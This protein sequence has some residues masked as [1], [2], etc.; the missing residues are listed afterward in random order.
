MER[1]EFK[2]R[3]KQYKKA[4]EENPGLKYWEWKDIPRYDV[5]TNS[6]DNGSNTSGIKT[7]FT[8][9]GVNWRKRPTQEQLDAFY[10]GD[11]Q[12]QIA[13]AQKAGQQITYS[14]PSY[15]LDEVVVTANRPKQNQYSE[16]DFAKDVAGFVP[17]LGDAIDIYDASKSLYDGNYSQ[18]ALL[19]AGLLL[20]NWLEKGGKYLYKGIRNNWRKFNR[21]LNIGINQNSSYFLGEHIS[22]VSDR[23]VEKNLRKL[24]IERYKQV[25]AFDENALNIVSQQYKN[26]QQRNAQSTKDAIESVQLHNIGK[27]TPTQ[28]R[29]IN[30]IFKED[31][32]YADFILAHPELNPLDVETV[33]RFVTKQNSFIRGVYSDQDNDGLIKS[34]MTENISDTSKK[35]G[36]D[37]LGTNSTGIYVSNSGEIA[38]KFQRTPYESVRSD[39]ALLSKKAATDINT[40]IK[41]RLAA[42]R[43]R[44]FPYDIVPGSDKLS[45]QSLVDLGYVAKEAQYTT[46]LGNKLP[47]YERAYISKELDQPTL[48]IN[49]LQTTKTNLDDKKGRWGIGGVQSVPELEDKLFDGF[50]IGTS[51]GDYL[52]L[53]RALKSPTLTRSVHNPQWNLDYRA[54]KYETEDLL[55]SQISKRLDLSRKVYNNP[56]VKIAQN[57][58]LNKA[59]IIGISGTIAG[60]GAGIYGI[61][62]S[63]TAK[64]RHR[65]NKAYKDDD[66]AKFARSFDATQYDS[67]IDMANAMLNQW[68]KNN[69]EKQ[70]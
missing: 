64:S 18:A 22:N 16:L 66:F 33:N 21:N 1:S 54:L 51:Y 32:R 14:N 15:T 24:G 58:S 23:I 70:Y 31:P 2:E 49:D 5:G 17:V 43:R 37:R 59:P 39:I 35:K 50:N 48:E 40:P 42:E 41:E 19:G 4:R 6:V 12:Q 65:L 46:R 67:S 38:D 13:L 27:F 9:D 28:L 25:P 53:M 8:T 62:N 56:Y 44:I 11:I 7:V 10:K 55:K 68:N 45:Y 69:P 47:G 36:G 34:M 26:A 63:D 20:P 61:M 3:L 30:E 52:H 57:I 29:E 60:V